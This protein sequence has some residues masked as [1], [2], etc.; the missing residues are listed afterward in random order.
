M[1]FN[2]GQWVVKP[3]VTPYHAEQI[4]DH[5]LSA[6]RTELYLFTLC[7][8]FTGANLDGPG[9]ELRISSPQEDM[10]RIQTVHFKGDRRKYRKFEI[11]D[12][13]IPLDYAEDEH[14]ITVTSGKT[15]LVITKSIPCSYTYLYDGKKITAIGDFFGRPMLDYIATPEG[16][17]MRGQLEV[18]VGEKIY[19]MGERFT[20]FVR[21]GQVVE[22]WNEDGGT[23]SE[24]SY[25]NIPF[26]LS[27][28]NYGVLVNEA[29]PVSFEV[30]AEAVTKVQFSVPGQRLDFIVIGAPDRKGVLERYTSLVGRPA[31]PPAWSFGLWLTTS[32]TTDYGEQ[33][34][35]GFVDGMAQRQIPLSVFHFDCFWMKESEWCGFDWDE[36]Q[37]PDVEGMLK[38]MH[39]KGLKICAWINPYIGQKAACFDECAE[40]GY[41]LKTPTGDIW[42][43]DR[44][45]PGQGVVDFTNPEAVAWYKGK[46][47]RLMEQGVDCFKTDFGE[48]IPTDVVYHDGSDPEWMHNY[49][50]YLYNKT[51]FEILEEIRGEGQACV[52]AR[53]ATVGGQKFP[54][55]WGGDCDSTYV[56][57]S[58]SLRGGLSLCL[59]GF[60]FW[61]HDIGGFSGTAPAHIYKRWL[62]FGLLSSHSRLHGSDS[63]RV[64]WLFGEEAV[65]VCRHFSQLKNSLMPYLYAQAVHTHQTGVPMMRAML[66][67]F[68]E[69]GCE[70][71]DRQY[72]LGDS[73]LV[74][75]VFR[76]DGVVD[77]YLPRGK[78]THLLTGETVDGNGWRRDSYDFFSLPVFVREN[79]ILPVG[80]C[81]LRPEY[82]YADGLTLRLYQFADGAEAERTVCDTQGNVI[83][84]AKAVRQGNTITVKLTG[85]KENVTLEQFGT[86]C[87]ILV[88]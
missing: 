62:A 86:D 55:H 60:G 31:L 23:S 61:S 52:F 27:S 40:K 80:S 65:D 66:L 4:R 82:D 18:D 68:D 16:P 77:Y 51:V 38:R 26:Y 20:P 84:T 44:W 2:I 3:G 54:V 29:G 70:D 21:N 37:F 46:L 88:V 79:T 13:R 34:V 43:W 71:L 76:E 24:I 47:R 74:A 32:F 58:E 64:P 15:S 22:I 41:F 59:S 67:E 75:P 63:Y 6:D 30:C 5:K 19:G 14:T 36:R 72:M 87:R 78:W 11:D 25:K 35:T 50:P 56:S 7:H 85:R 8:Q 57:M 48:R 81:N 17:F 73:I 53:S 69:I 28:R 45:Q 10:I 49:Y 83:L 1:K 9:L 42:Q 39:E 33:T 12:R